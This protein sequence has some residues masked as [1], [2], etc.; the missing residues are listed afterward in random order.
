MEASKRADYVW[1]IHEQ[2]KA[3]IMKMGKTVAEKRN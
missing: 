2:T 1:K 3:T